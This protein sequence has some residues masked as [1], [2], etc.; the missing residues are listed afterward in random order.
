MGSPRDR[1]GFGFKDTKG[2]IGAGLID[3]SRKFGLDLKE[4][5]FEV[6]VEC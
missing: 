5:G 4:F 6:V 1:S 3:L 2:A